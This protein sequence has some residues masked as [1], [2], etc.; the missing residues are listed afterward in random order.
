M[1]FIKKSPFPPNLPSL[2]RDLFKLLWTYPRWL[3]A[4]ILSTII[5]SSLEPSMAWMSKSFIDDLKDSS[6]VNISDSLHQYIVKFG[7]I[8]LGL[9]IIKF[10]DKIIDKIF[11]TK[12]ILLLQTTYLDRRK[13]ENTTE[14]V[15]KIL[16]D[17]NK[18][19]P[20]IDVIHK[21]SWKIVSQTISVI[22]WQL[23]LAPEWLP[24]LF[25]AVLPPM[26]IGFIFSGFIQKASLKTLE[27]QAK[28]AS[29]TTKEK[30]LEFARHQDSFLSQVMRLEMFKQGTE[31]LV[32]LLTWFGL[33]ILVITASILPFNILPQQITA[34]DLVLFWVN[35]NLLSKPLGEIAKVYNK[36]RE[37]YP[38]LVRVLQP[39]N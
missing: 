2:I 3:I 33:L 27:I 21:D 18:A 38:A 10:G 31:I 35:L 19:K 23:N 4:A 7:G 16:F 15:S 29:S 32:D 28:I 20:G 12:L 24:A 5:L 9:A 22:I 30:N 1:L 34:G 8:F 6:N 13:Q 14:D 26:F 36:A 39:N 11:E 25:I 37:S 17:C